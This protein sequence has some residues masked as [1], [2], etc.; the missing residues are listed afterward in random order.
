MKCKFFFFFWFSCRVLLLQVYSQL[1]AEGSNNGLLKKVNGIINSK[2]EGVTSVSIILRGEG[3]VHRWRRF[4]KGDPP[5]QQTIRVGVI[6]GSEREQLSIFDSKDFLYF[7]LFKASRMSTYFG[8]VFQYLIKVISIFH[9]FD[10]P[11]V[12]GVFFS[13]AVC[14]YLI[15]V[16]SMFPP[17]AKPC[18]HD[19][20]FFGGTFSILNSG[21]FENLSILLVWG[22]FPKTWNKWFVEIYGKFS[23]N[24]LLAFPLLSHPLQAKHCSLVSIRCYTWWEPAQKK[25]A[26]FNHL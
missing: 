7:D 22:M 25:K 12:H 19:V 10:W 2:L 9:P 17:W 18:A 14:H 15:E 20:L 1:E 13:G 8:V 3:W 5:I 21:N 6:V 11:C 24:S 23:G 4:E 26:K 16:I